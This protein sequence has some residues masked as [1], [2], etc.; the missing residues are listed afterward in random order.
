MGE[1]ENSKRA[2]E[3]FEERAK[4]KTPYTEEQ[5]NQKIED[6]IEDYYS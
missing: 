5:F 6:A 2:F 1:Y 3:I 4:G